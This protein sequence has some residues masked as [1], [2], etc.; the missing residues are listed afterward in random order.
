M[1]TVYLVL[2]QTSTNMKSNKTIPVSSK[3]WTQEM[4][5]DLIKLVK[6]DRGLWEPDNEFYQKRSY[7]YQAYNRISNEM[8]VLWPNYEFGAVK[9]M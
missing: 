5:K 7:R 9:L 8:K 3:I 4:E 1:S 2:D 6:E